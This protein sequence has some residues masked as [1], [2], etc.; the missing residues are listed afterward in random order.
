V[1]YSLSIR[2]E[3]EADIAEAYQYY[4]SCR[5]DLGADFILCIDESISRI[6]KNPRQYKVIHKNVHRALVRR[7]PFGI[8]YVLIDSNI[9]II[10]VLH[11][12]K[13]PK[14]WQARS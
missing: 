1:L 10:A 2:K 7:F 13:N 5:E 14:H 3:A 9:V 11:A 4:E 12:R 6:K 8:Y